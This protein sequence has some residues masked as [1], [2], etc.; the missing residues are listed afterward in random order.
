MLMTQQEWEQELQQ[1]GES[2]A[3]QLEVTGMVSDDTVE[4]PLFGHLCADNGIPATAR[5]L[6][7]FFE[8]DR[9]TVLLGG[10]MLRQPQEGDLPTDMQIARIMLDAEI[11]SMQ[12]MSHD[13]ND[14][15]DERDAD[16]R[17]MELE[18]A[19]Q[20]ISPTAA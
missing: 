14:P 17:A 12:S 13:D 15:Q 18:V 11:R 10:V 9:T 4:I 5:S 8:A 19:L 1:H 3:V 6:T 20:Q 2:L 16:Q 7:Q